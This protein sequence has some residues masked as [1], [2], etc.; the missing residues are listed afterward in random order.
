ME[1]NIKKVITVFTNFWISYMYE[2][3]YYIEKFLVSFNKVY[4]KTMILSKHYV[5]VDVYWLLYQHIVTS[6]IKYIFYVSHFIFSYKIFS[7]QWYLSNVLLFLNIPHE[8]NSQSRGYIFISRLHFPI[9][10]SLL[11]DNVAFY[12]VRIKQ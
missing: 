3:Y 8:H 9:S 5:D 4:N 6:H 11:L 1:L 10:L 12:E 7:F 2:F